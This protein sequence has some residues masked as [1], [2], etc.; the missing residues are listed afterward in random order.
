MADLSNMIRLLIATAVTSF[1]AGI[2]YCDIRFN[3]GERRALHGVIGT[4]R[5]E[6]KKAKEA[7]RG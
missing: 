1:I 6:L 3:R 5:E 4:L 2:L 7:L